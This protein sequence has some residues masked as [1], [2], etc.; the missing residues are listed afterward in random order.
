MKLQKTLATAIAVAA[1]GSFTVSNNLIAATG[2][3]ITYTASGTF[4]STPVSGTDT[5]KLAGE[6]FSVSVAVN[7]ATVPYKTGSN[8]DAYNKL[9]LTGTVHSGLLGPTPVN[10]T[11]TESSIIQAI[12][13]KQYDL[14]TMEAPIKVVGITLT[15]KAQIVMPIGT[16]TKPILAPFTTVTLAPGNATL[17]YSDSGA[18]TVLS[19]Q[20]GTLSAT[21]PGGE[22]TKAVVLH[23]NGVQAVTLHA[24]GTSSAQSI[25]ASPLDLGISSDSVALKFY[26]AG[27]RG[28]SEVHVQIAGE[29]VPVVYAAASGY[30]P[31]LD[32]VTVQVPRSMSGLGAAEVTLIVDGQSA[33]PVKIHIQ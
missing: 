14:F 15:I 30:F 25:G 12:D 26:A 22:V 31:G 16:I 4:A 21:V 6:P 29:E 8:W 24:D 11:S 18:S 19:I 17:T 20:T 27:V 1:I 32:E 23:S 33:N 9:A 5:L 28:A 10:I 2:Q 7:S 3:T 13:P